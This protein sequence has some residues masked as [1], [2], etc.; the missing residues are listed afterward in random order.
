MHKNLYMGC[1][2]SCITHQDEGRVLHVSQNMNKTLGELDM[3]KWNYNTFFANS[4][5]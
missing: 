5:H 1:L 3:A 2:Q 4:L